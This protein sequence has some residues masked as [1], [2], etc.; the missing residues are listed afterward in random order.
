[1]I[2]SFKD[3]ATSDIA[4]EIRS[5]AARKLLPESQHDSAYRKLIFLDNA[6]SLQDILNWRG[7]RLEKL[8]GDRAGQY[9]IRI[10]DQ[11]RICFEWK[12]QD[13][14]DVTIVDYH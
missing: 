10:N 9:S 4:R 5:K 11:Y 3:T 2:R 8:K 1:M 6:T 14:F 12:G 7:L 13:A